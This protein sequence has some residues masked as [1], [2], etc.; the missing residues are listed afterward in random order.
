[1]TY[2][3]FHLLFNVPLLALLLWLGRKRLTATHWKWIGAICGV[4]LAFTFPWD[5]W[6]VGRGIW[7]FDD[8]RVLARIGHLPIEEIGFFL[9]ET[10]VVCLIALHFL[11][12]RREK[13]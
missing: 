10:L 1:M 3:E 7:E 13:G 12:T 5:N 4:V 11:P 6:A 2:L 8:A 9:I